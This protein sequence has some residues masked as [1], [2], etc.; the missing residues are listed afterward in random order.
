MNIKFRIIV[1]LL[2]SNTLLAQNI[3]VGSIDMAKSKE[4]ET[5]SY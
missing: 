2:I 1:F 5:S 3:P 4:P